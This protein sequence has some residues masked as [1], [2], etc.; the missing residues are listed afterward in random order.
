MRDPVVPLVAKLKLRAGRTG[1]NVVCQQLARTSRASSGAAVRQALLKSLGWPRFFEYSPAAASRGVT[2]FISLRAGGNLEVE[3]GGRVLA[4]AACLPGGAVR[5]RPPSR[6]RVFSTRR[7]ATAEI[8]ACRVCAVLSA[9]RSAGFVQTA[10]AGR[11][12]GLTSSGAWDGDSVDGTQARDPRTTSL[13]ETAALEVFE[14]L[15]GCGRF[16][17]LAV[18]IPALGTDELAHRSGCSTQGEAGKLAV[19]SEKGGCS[20]QGWM[21]AGVAGQHDG[22]TGGGPLAAG[23]WLFRVRFS[24]ERTN[25]AKKSCWR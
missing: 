1:Q 13:H 20:D 21:R 10:G 14:P 2:I 7:V 18:R 6:V 4:D 22:S 9:R 19:A 25:V 15:I 11:T 5:P 3:T 16:C 8:T 24:E 12:V 23:G 17:S